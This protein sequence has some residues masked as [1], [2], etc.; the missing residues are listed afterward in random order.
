MVALTNVLHESWH[1]QL[2]DRFLWW[3]AIYNIHMK[4]K[5][6]DAN[7]IQINTAISKN[8]NNKKTKVMNFHTK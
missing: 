8:K 2:I 6:H 4:Q 1:L 7:F 5:N 3:C